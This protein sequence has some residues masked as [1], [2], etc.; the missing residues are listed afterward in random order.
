M[1]SVYTLPEF[2][3]RL[4]KEKGAAGLGLSTSYSAKR[5]KGRV[6]I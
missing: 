2:A 4:G 6:F 5:V 1:N 3:L